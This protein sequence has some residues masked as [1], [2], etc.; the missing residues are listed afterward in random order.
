MENTAVDTAPTDHCI[1]NN[2]PEHRTVVIKTEE[3]I[4]VG[5]PHCGQQ[6][7]DREREEHPAMKATATVPP[8]FSMR[9]HHSQEATLT[10]T[11]ANTA[12]EGSF[13]AALRKLAQQAPNFPA[14]VLPREQ[15]G[16]HTPPGHATKNMKG[17][18]NGYR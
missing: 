3:S 7:E 16:R 11:S 12:S 4:P 15:A 13:A 8:F 5:V 9:N 14:P 17:K 2:D 6:E 10:T 1:S 18:F